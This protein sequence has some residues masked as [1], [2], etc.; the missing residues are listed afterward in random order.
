[1]LTLIAIHV[2][3]H[4]LRNTTF[5]RIL[6]TLP[7]QLAALIVTAPRIQRPLQRIALPTEQVIAVV[8]VSSSINTIS[9]TPSPHRIEK[10][11]RVTHTKHERLR[12]VASPELGLIK[13]HRIEHDLIHHL[14]QHNRK[15]L[16]TLSPLLHRR[17]RLNIRLIRYLGVRDVALVVRAIE[18]HAVPA[19]GE[20]DLGADATFA[21]ARGE[22][23]GVAFGAGGAAEGLSVLV[24]AAVADASGFAGCVAQEGVTGEHAEALS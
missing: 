8:A 23:G 6:I 11:I 5:H 1:L 22:E 14:R 13:R 3:H 9:I 17:K 7:L 2:L 16:R 10:Y 15:A 12:P 19:R 21:H 20:R 18:V 4:L 24:Y